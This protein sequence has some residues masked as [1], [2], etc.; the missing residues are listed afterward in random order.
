MAINDFIISTLNVSD[1]MIFSI[2]TNKSSDKLHILIKLNDTHPTC[3]CCGGYT[4]IKDYS[5]YSYNHLDVAG[6]PSIIDWTRRRYVCKECG[7]SFSEPNPYR[8]QSITLTNEQLINVI[9]SITC[10]QKDDQ[11]RMPI[12]A[13]Y[14]HPISLF[15]THYL[16]Q[17][18]FHESLPTILLKLY[19]IT[20]ST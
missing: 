15:K 3:P 19:M 13:L 20:Y 8:R 1:D 2:D 18:G 14:S 16:F 10:I 11:I 4:K 12:L 5:S 7:K 9:P 17:S 6:I